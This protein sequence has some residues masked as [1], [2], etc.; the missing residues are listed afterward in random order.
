MTVHSNDGISWLTKLERLGEKSAGDKQ[1]MFNNLGHLLNINMLKEQ[2]RRLDRNKAVGI[3]GV[4][5]A[6]YEEKP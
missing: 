6:S 4:T 3:D 1:M 5:K 2:F